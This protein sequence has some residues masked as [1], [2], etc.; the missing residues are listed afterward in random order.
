[1]LPLIKERLKSFKAG[2]SN[3]T[4]VFDKGNVSKANQQRV[5]DLKLHYVTGMTVASQKK[6]VGTANQNLSPVVLDDEETV[7]AYRTEAR[8]WGKRRTAVVLISET[9]KQGQ[10]RGILQHVTK[11]GKWL[12][13]LADTLGRGKQKRDR[14]TLE[15]DIQKRLNGRQ[16]LRHVLTYRLDGQE[17]K[18]TLTYQFHQQALDRLANETLGRLVLITDRKE[19]TTAEIIGGYRSQANIEAL[20]AHLKDPVHI[21]L[22]PQFHW[23]DQKLHVHVFTCVLAHLLARLLFLKAQRAKMPFRS[24]EKLLETLGNVRSS[25]VLQRYGSSKKLH[26]ANILEDVDEALAPHL[27]S[28]GIDL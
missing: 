27:A 3:L 26:V 6:L 14:A 19:W 5:D 7:M 23:T 1:M 11:A 10:I 24:Q 25:T 28:L 12:A 22:R 8:I 9:L 20:F 17:P 18:L 15:R 2:L 16:H 4:I 13:D 21:A